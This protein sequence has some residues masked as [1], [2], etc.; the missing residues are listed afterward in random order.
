LL[1][2]IY[3]SRRAALRAAKRDNNIPVA[4]PPKEVVTPNTPER[5]KDEGL[6]YRNRRLYIFEFLL[7]LLT[8]RFHIRE[9]KEAIYPD[10]K[11]NQPAHFNAG[12]PPEKLKKHYYFKK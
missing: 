2:I 10:D 3:E 9:D 12:E 11:G 5:W 4:T 8:F 1:K 6:D 7:N